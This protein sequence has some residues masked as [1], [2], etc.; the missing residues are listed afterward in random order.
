MPYEFPQKQVILEADYH[1]VPPPGPLLPAQG[2]RPLHVPCLL[3]VE[4]LKS[5]RLPRATKDQDQAGND[6]DDRVTD[7]MSDAH[8]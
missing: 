6:E 4:K 3:F 2:Q 5:P 8:S 1:V 7:S